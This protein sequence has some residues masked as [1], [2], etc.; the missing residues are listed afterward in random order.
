MA[1][2]P[3]IKPFMDLVV[4]S[5]L[6]WDF[7]Y[8]RPQ[9]LISRFA[10]EHRVWFLEEPILGDDSQAFLERSPRE[11]QL[12]VC[13]PHLPHGLSEV[14]SWTLQRELLDEL[15]AEEKITNLVTWYYSPMAMNFS[16]HLAPLATVYDCMDELSAFRGAPPGL[17]AAEAELFRRADL[18]FTG[19]HRLYEAKKRQHSNVFA[20]P[21]SIDAL[22]FQ[23][24][25]RIKHDPE[26]QREIPHPRLGFAGVIDERLDIQLLRAA[27]A[28]RP[29]W[30][31]VMIGPVVKISQEDLPQAKNIHYLG[32]K[33]YKQLPFYMAGWD[34]GILPFARNEATKFISP[35]K[36]PE[37]LAAGLPVV[38]TYIRDVARP[39]GQKK[40]AKIVNTPEAFIAASERLLAHKHDAQRLREVDAFLAGNSWDI[41]WESMKQLLGKA[42]LAKAGG[43]KDEEGISVNASVS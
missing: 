33:D 16:R 41:T 23:Q 18:V 37:Y 6:R 28:M 2:L 36:T 3:C 20:F 32:A 26:D 35:T 11:G 30:H 9:H 21:S 15:I 19:G 5:H 24:A 17:R 10:R 27:A 29:A 40:L 4:F 1:C 14:E 25:R 8:Q 22:H 43:M 34:V 13:R 12:E 42:T 7:V 31:F 39:Y 38:S